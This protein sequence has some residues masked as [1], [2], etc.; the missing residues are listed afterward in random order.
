MRAGL[1]DQEDARYR[2]SLG[3]LS[4]LSSFSSVGAGLKKLDLCQTDGQLLAAVSPSSTLENPVS[5]ETRSRLSLANF[6]RTR[7][8]AFGDKLR[9]ILASLWQRRNS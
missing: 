9:G 1:S 2:F 6:Y 3:R 8:Q 7:S 5:C 4:E